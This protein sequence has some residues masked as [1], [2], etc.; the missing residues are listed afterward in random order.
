MEA[1]RHYRHRTLEERVKI[2]S[3]VARLRGSGMSVKEVSEVLGISR[4]DVSYWT[5]MNEPSRT[6]YNPDLSP[7]PEL[8]Y[9][10]GAYP[11]DGRTAG[12]QDKKVRFKVADLEFAPLLND[13]VAK[14]IGARLKSIS[15]DGGFHSVSYDCAGLYDFLQQPLSAQI[16]LAETFPAEFLRGFFDAEGYASQ[17]IRSGSGALTAI[18]VGAANCNLDYLD[19]AR[20]LLATLE[21]SSEIRMTNKAGQPREIRGRTYI[22]KRNAFQVRVD[23]TDSV[24]K[25]QDRVGF[26]VP[27]KK[28]KLADLVAMMSIPD[29]WDRYNHFTDLYEKKGR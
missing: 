6:V 5:R 26:S 10:V 25:F 22:R 15:L 19:L 29:E 9:L 7:R 1:R 12:Q 21:M 3:E 18:S 4:R 28:Q 14:V 8:T 17:T 13:L 20:R 23:E 2:R 16:P 27:E 11:G 24:E